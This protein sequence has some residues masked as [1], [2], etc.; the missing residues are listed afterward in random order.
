MKIHKS[1]VMLILIVLM[2]LTGC[3]KPGTDL[4]P[5]IDVHQVIIPAVKSAPA[6]TK[7]EVRTLIVFAAA[8]LTGAFQEIG[9]DF[10]AANPGVMVSFNFA[11]SQ[12]LR[13]QL[14]QGASADIIASAD[15]KNMDLLV[16]DNLVASNMFQDFVTNKLIVILPPGNPVDFRVLAD[17]ARPNLK[18]VLADSSVPAGNYARQ[19][20]STMSMDPFYGADFST[21]VLANVVSNETDVKQV[22]TKVELGEADAGIVYVSDAIATPDL[23]TVSIPDKFNIIANYPIA[24]LSNA[25]NPALAESFVTY[26]TSSSGQATFNK[27]GFSPVSH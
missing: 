1:W 21:R 25:P 20:L 12:I 14:E 19:L 27:W 3:D 13:T 8:S 6:T 16:A 10:E 22:V 18:L 2:A 7:P 5:T 4:P 17:L 26:V 23:V 15:H 11:G 9:K 24:I